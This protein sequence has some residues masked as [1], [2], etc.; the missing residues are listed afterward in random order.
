MAKQLFDHSYDTHTLA[1]MP[2]KFVDGCDGI[3]SGGSEPFARIR[4]LPSA[5][6]AHNFEYA[7]PTVAWAYVDKGKAFP[8][9]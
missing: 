4:S 6:H 5:P 1:G 3:I 9:R 8:V 2:V 7:W